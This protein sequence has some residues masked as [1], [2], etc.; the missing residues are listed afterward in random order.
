MSPNKANCHI[1]VLLLLQYLYTFVWFYRLKWKPKLKLS[2]NGGAY[3]NQIAVKSR[4]RFSVN[5][6]T[7]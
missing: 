7:A 6:C 2:L 4:N 5:T 1:I 3:L